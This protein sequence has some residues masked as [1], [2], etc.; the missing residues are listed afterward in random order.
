MQG[1]VRAASSRRLQAPRL[2]LRCAPARR[3]SARA[4]PTAWR[5]R[6]VAGGLVVLAL[7]HNPHNRGHRFFRGCS[8]AWGEFEPELEVACGD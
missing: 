2:P 7:L 4:S 5:R 6:R 8:G 3:A 1:A